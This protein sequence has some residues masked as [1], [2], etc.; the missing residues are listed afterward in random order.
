MVWGFSVFEVLTYHVSSEIGQ[1]DHAFEFKLLQVRA[2]KI[3]H[4]I[5]LEFGVYNITRC[6][7]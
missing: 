7:N 1:L 3:T 2:C 5:T 4:I 6:R